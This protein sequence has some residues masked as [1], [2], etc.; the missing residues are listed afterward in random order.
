MSRGGQH[1]AGVLQNGRAQ[2]MILYTVGNA[3]DG[4]TEFLV[5]GVHVSKARSVARLMNMLRRRRLEGHPVRAGQ[6]AGS[7]DGSETFTIEAPPN[8]ARIRKDAPRRAGTLRV[9]SLSLPRRASRKF[10]TSRASR[11][12]STAPSA[13]AF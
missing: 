5:R 12:G 1:I 7:D 9:S 4:G 13:T 6:R 10:R 3:S 2:T 8:V 11:R